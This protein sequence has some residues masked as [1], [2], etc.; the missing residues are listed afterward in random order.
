MGHA[1]RALALAV[2]L[3]MAGVTEPQPDCRDALKRL[4]ADQRTDRGP[5]VEAFYRSLAYDLAWVRD[6]KPTTQARAM[7]E[8]FGA[9]ETRGLN[10]E[11]YDTSQWVSRLDRFRTRVSAIDLARF[12]L[13]LTVSVMRYV[14]DLHIGRVNPRLFHAGF[15]L[16][17]ETYDLAE[18]VRTRLVQSKDIPAALAEIEPP[19]PGYRRTR[20][21]LQNYLAIAAEGDNERL[22]V[23][24]KPVEPDSSYP[25][26]A[27]LARLLQRL[28]DFPAGGIVSENVYQG[29]L[30]DAVRRFQRRHGL[31]P[32]G[33]IGPATY[34]C[35]NTTIEQRVRQLALTLERYR[36]VPHRF[37]RPPVVVNI[38]EFRLRALD[39]SYRVELEMKIVVGRAYRHQTPVFAREMKFVIFRPYWE[40][41]PSIQRAELVP[42]AARDRSYLARNGYE[43]ITAA[44]GVV[45]RDAPDDGTLRQLGAGKARIRQIP[46]PQNSLGLV[47][48]LFPN[49]YNVYMHGTPATE[50]FSRSRRDFSHGCIRLERPEA[51]AAWV[52]R[53]KPG[54][55]SQRIG[56]AMH[57]ERTIQVNLDKPIPVLIVYATAVVLENGEVHFF[58]DIYGHD[59]AL[60]KVLAAG[61]PY[62]QPDLTSGARGPHPRE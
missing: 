2:A 47:K 6:G 21:A 29:A 49:E 18:L 57:G 44:G 19:F 8:V 38:P 34:R 10:P 20:V 23:T 13:A 26:A 4:L 52:L 15:D 27:R 30:V 28:G 50:L 48:F 14:S 62:P 31:D 24:L 5:S 22:R 45:K 58:D 61:S 32:D 17:R 60:A 7:I 9:A 55:N 33:R 36:W 11:D 43:I 16:A 46:G 51:L 35:L 25:E 40:V 56:E 37:D 53:D 1:W 12:D 42:R 54:W 59:A 41:P 39:D 3:A